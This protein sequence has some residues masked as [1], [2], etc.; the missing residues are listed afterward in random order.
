MSEDREILSR[1]RNSTASQLALVL[2]CILRGCLGHVDQALSLTYLDPPLWLQNAFR[3]A[4]GQM[5]YRDYSYPYPAL[6]IAFIGWA[7][8]LFGGQVHGCR[9]GD[10]VISLGI[11][12]A[13]FALVLQ[14][15]PRAL[16]ALTCIRCVAVCATAQSYFSLFSSPGY[17][18]SLRG[19]LVFCC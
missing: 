2:G 4:D 19:R 16:Q 3:F 12:I 17:T 6:G 7:F 5:P 8:R 10:D 1:P 9:D 15:M 18:P 14:S 11:V 13:V